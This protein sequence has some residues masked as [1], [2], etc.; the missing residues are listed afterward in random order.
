MRRQPFD[1]NWRF[2]LGDPPDAYWLALD[3]SSWPQIDLPH[4]W[5]IGLERGPDQPCGNSGGYFPMGRGWYRKRIEAP[6]AWRGGRV[7]LEF[8]G[9]YMN[10]E[11]WL[12]EILAAILRLHQLPG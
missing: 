3:D 9:V 2:H 4:D 6:E 8:E 11:I 5:S 10:A 1:A 12:D 7:S